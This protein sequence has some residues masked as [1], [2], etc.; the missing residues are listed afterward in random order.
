MYVGRTS[1]ALIIPIF[2]NCRIINFAQSGQK[3]H[4]PKDRFG[5]RTRRFDFDAAFVTVSCTWNERYVDLG[6]LE[7]IGGKVVEVRRLEIGTR[8]L[9]PGA[10][11]GCQR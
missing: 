8:V 2:I 4:F 1:L 6:R 7:A 11:L 9:Q 5:P 10:F 3:R